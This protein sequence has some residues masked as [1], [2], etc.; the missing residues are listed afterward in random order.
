MSLGYGAKVHVSA[1]IIVSLLSSCLDEENQAFPRRGQAFQEEGTDAGWA[2][3][4]VLE[5]LL[6]LLSARL[7]TLPR[8]L[9]GSE[10]GNEPLGRAQ[11]PFLRSMVPLQVKQSDPRDLCD[12]AVRLDKSHA[13]HHR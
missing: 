12:I 4:G 10:A 5:Y 9:R 6:T 1:W 8:Q 7:L 2:T 11:F 13:N 3:S